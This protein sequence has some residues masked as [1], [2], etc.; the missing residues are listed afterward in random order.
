MDQAITLLADAPADKSRAHK[1]TALALKSRV[2]THAASDLYK[3][4]K[5]SSVATIATYQNKELVGYTGGSQTQ[6]WEAAKNASK[7][8]LDATTGY[9][10]DYSAPAPFDEAVQNYGDIWL[11]GYKNQDFIWGV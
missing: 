5:A 4:S 9:K 6:R 1:I 7:Q 3:P 2:L 10:L 8:L 11:Q